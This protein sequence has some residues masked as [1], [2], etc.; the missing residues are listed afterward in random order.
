MIYEW[1]WR[2]NKRLIIFEEA[3]SECKSRRQK[4]RVKKRLSDKHRK[5]NMEYRNQNNLHN[6]RKAFWI[7]FLCFSLLDFLMQ[8]SRGLFFLHCA[9]G[10]VYK[11]LMIR[12]QRHYVKRFTFVSP[13][14][15]FSLFISTTLITSSLSKRAAKL[16]HF[17]LVCAL[18]LNHRL[19]T[20]WKWFFFNLT[21]RFFL[22]LPT[23]FSFAL[24]LWN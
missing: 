24:M 6:T 21:R 19:W 8:C 4:T 20:L 23:N 2:S 17:F 3:W 13:S 22:S 9:P 11:M 14:A 16:E 7:C 10:S 12:N 15:F 1:R 18:R 5:I